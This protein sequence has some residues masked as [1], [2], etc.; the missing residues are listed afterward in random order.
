M[1]A[2]IQDV[3]AD[4]ALH[5]AVLATQDESVAVLLGAGADPTILNSKGFAP[6]HE[7]AKKGFCA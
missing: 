6:I 3:D 5:F 4:T 1:C 2:H 7:A